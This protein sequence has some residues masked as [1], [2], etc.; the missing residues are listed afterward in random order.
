M[1][2][3]LVI[4][5]G[6]IGDFILTLPAIR[7]IAEGLPDTQVDVL[8][9]KPIAELARASGLV[10]DT[11]SI[12]HGPLAGFFAP[13]AGLD[14]GWCEY[15]AGFDLVV[16]Y[17]H[18]RDGHFKANLERAG[19]KSLLEGISKVDPATGEHAARQL[20]RVLE[21]VALFLDDPAPRLDLPDA[22]DGVSGAVA[23]HP[24]SGGAAK[25]WR[26]EDWIAVG[27][28]VASRGDSPRLLLV[29]GEAEHA[30][31]DEVAGAWRARGVDFV[32]A[33]GWDLPRLGSALAGC[34][35][36]LGHDSG[37]SHLAAAVGAPCLLLFGP[38]DP[39]VWA[40]ANEA[41]EVLRS[42]TGQ[43]ADIGREPVEEAVARLLGQ[44]GR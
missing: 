23:I 15:F 39:A 36:F 24:G 14:P 38:T 4:R 2:K 13:G 19:V 10:A 9:H 3:V 20:A 41:V 6:A 26:L 7:L 43:M 1:G 18:D 22:G 28:A 25:N 21:N 37:I 11:R 31:R 34:R 5:G 29:T 27:E 40:P 35:L 12:E 16:S 32:H 17:L 30:K 42:E 33:D 44:A 8:G